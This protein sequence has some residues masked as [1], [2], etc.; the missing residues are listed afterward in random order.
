MNT[1]R[2]SACLLLVVASTLFLAACGS[3][4]EGSAKSE[5]ETTT[6]LV[7]AEDS[8]TGEAGD[9]VTTQSAPSSSEDSSSDDDSVKETCRVLDEVD[10]ITSG[11]LGTSL[12]SRRENA[13]KLGDLVDEAVDVA[14]AEIVDAFD[15]LTEFLDEAVEATSEATTID[16]YEELGS[17]VDDSK[18]DDAGT[19]IQTWLD[20]NCEA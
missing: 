11:E 13:D 4:S 2:S 20:A 18:F 17:Q 12:E 6:S 9:G 15:T 1:S 8:A 5:K 14:P 7:A 16:E 19:D 3:D 10:K